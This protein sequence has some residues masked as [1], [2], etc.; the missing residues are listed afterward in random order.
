MVPYRL[1]IN[2]YC[3]L[4]LLG[5]FHKTAKLYNVHL[6]PFKFFICYQKE[7]KQKL[8]QLKIQCRDM[9]RP[10]VRPEQQLGQQAS[11][12]PTLD[13]GSHVEQGDTPPIPIDKPTEIDGTDLE[14]T[15]RL[16]DHLG[17]SI[18]AMMPLI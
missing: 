9:L 8:D 1:A 2:S 3:V 18:R 6:R 13:V 5:L 10:K 11:N 15:Q 17:K 12:Q 14:K 7:L 4:D 16:R